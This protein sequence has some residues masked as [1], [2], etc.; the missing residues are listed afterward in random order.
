MQFTIHYDSERTPNTKVILV[1]NPKEC[2]VG[3]Y[4]VHPNLHD[5]WKLV[6]RGLVDSDQYQETL[7]EIK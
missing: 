7:G 1:E 3:C 4:H 5:H 2:S 6:L